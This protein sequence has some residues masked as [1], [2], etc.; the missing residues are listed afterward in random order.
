MMFFSKTISKIKYG[1][2]VL[3][4]IRKA[5]RHLEN[6]LYR[7][8]HGTIIKVNHF[9]IRPFVFVFS[10]RKDAVR[11]YDECHIIFGGWSRKVIFIFT[12][13]VL[14]FYKN[15]KKYLG[16]RNN[17]E[18]YLSLC[19]YPKCKYLSF[20]DKKRTIISSKEKGQAANDHC[21]ARLAKSIIRLNRHAEKSY[22]SICE[23]GIRIDNI[24]TY[25]QHGDASRS[26]I[27]VDG[28]EYCFI[29]FDTI[30]HYPALFD[31]F[32]LLLDVD[33][34][35]DQFI[36]GSFDHELK[37]FFEQENID[38]SDLEKDKYLACF[39]LTNKAWVKRIK[40][41]KLPRIYRLSLKVLGRISE[42]T[43]V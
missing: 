29:D 12:D 7:Y 15:R 36:T 2:S 37:Q 30:N 10:F 42:T 3:V 31:F 9:G 33:E 43:K 19:N 13:I 32:R 38:Y 22:T 20:D 6:G 18:K 24:L 14:S 11:V 8:D 27:L 35:L 5:A 4:Y 39:F 28:D 41:E 1:F 25:I 26:N 17:M 40:K 16:V 21:A 34:G 23:E